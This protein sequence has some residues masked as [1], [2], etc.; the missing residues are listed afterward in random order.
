[1]PTF[2]FILSPWFSSLLGRSLDR[3]P[4]E[5]WARYR[6]V[7][8]LISFLK[9]RGARDGKVYQVLIAGLQRQTLVSSQPLMMKERVTS[10]DDEGKSRR[11]CRRKIHTVNC[12]HAWQR[13]HFQN[14][15]STSPVCQSDMSSLQTLDSLN[16]GLC[17]AEENFG[18]LLSYWNNELMAKQVRDKFMILVFCMIAV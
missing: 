5:T 11:R 10:S 8:S 18:R 9:R 7:V 16:N 2:L 17:R 3:S 1:M 12:Y 6:S 4:V 14:D 13:L 15:K